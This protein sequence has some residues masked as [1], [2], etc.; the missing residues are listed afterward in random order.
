M[1]Y[2][3]KMSPG[4][5]AYGGRDLS[6]AKCPNFGRGSGSGRP[7]PVGQPRMISA[8]PMP[9]RGSAGWQQRSNEPA[10]RAGVGDLAQSA[11]GQDGVRSGR[12]RKDARRL[13]AGARL[14][15]R[16]LGEVASR[17]PAAVSSHQARLR[18][19][20]RLS[21]M[22]PLLPQSDQGGARTSDRPVDPVRQGFWR[23][24]DRPVHG[25]RIQRPDLPERAGRRL[26][27]AT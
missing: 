12:P 11:D 16:D 17:R 20:L 10:L 1:A 14:R 24:G 3:E 2:G 9:G 25:R 7:V 26:S 19:L 4:M 13:A 18:L 22:G 8:L 5:K 23:R 21:P 15:H 6:L 27:A